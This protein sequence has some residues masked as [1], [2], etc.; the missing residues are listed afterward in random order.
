MNARQKFDGSD[1]YVIV[2]H[3]HGSPENIWVRGVLHEFVLFFCSHS[4]LTL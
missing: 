4:R 1:S 3:L 2:F